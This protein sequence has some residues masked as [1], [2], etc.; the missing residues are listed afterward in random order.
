[1][2]D[3][4][5][6]RRTE[7]GVNFAGV[8]VTNDIAPYL[9][10]LSYTD[11]EEDETDDLQIKLHDREGIWREKWL[12]NLIVASTG[13]KSIKSTDVEGKYKV[14]AESGVAVRAKSGT[15]YRKLGTLAFGTVIT[16]KSVD[17]GW[18]CFS[19]SGSDAYV[20]TDYLQSTSD[21]YSKNDGTAHKGMRIQAAI[22]RQNWNGDGKDDLLECGQFEL[23]SVSVQGPPSAITI[24]GTSLPYSSTV[25]QTAKSKSWENYTLSGIAKEMANKNGMTCMFLSSANPAYKRIEQY[26]VSDIAFLQ[27][28]CQ[29][30][31]C[32]LKVSNN[33]IIIFDQ[34]EYEKRPIVRTFR[35]GD[36]SIIKYKISTGSD[37]TYSSC[38][39]SYVT[40]SGQLIEA[41][42]YIDGYKAETDDKQCLEVS[43]K[44]SGI[45][46]AQTIAEKLLRLHN[47]YEITGSITVP[48]DPRLLAGCVVALSG[49]GAFDGKYVI[50]KAFHKAGSDGYTTQITLRKALSTDTIPADDTSGASGTYAFTV[51]DK[52]MCNEGVKTFSHGAR[53][54]SW[55]PVTPLY[56]RKIEQGGKVLLLSNKPSGNVYTGRVWASDVHKI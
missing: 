56:V 24:K 12:N 41:T 8:D 46:E 55:V 40:P 4:S 54:Q 1:M 44:V 36:G 13:N 32:S 10:S 29:L 33:V 37:N 20:K 34:S 48:G 42:A 38:R 15:R 7:I 53:M 2:S 28:L 45:A 27:K 23:D 47:K 31:G 25:R 17:K 22:V 14:I 9:L 30:C 39:V 21:D 19:Y 49:W 16:A 51:G 50:S 11:N 18:A 6:A 3:K 5:L 26:K 43:Q 52:V 35:Y